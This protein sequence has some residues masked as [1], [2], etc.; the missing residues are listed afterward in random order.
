MFNKIV[1]FFQYILN[2]FQEPPKLKLYF[3]DEREAPKGW[4]VVRPNEI[5]TVLM[6]LFYNDDFAERVEAIS[7]DHDLGIGYPSGYEIF[8]RIEEEY[9]NDSFFPPM[10]YVHSMNPAGRMNIVRGINSL[11]QRLGRAYNPNILPK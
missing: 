3:D 7:F 10:L 11:N 4:T 1:E 9:H 8:C 6:E 2:F 5:R